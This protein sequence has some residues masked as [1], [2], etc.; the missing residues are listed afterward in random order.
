ML[1]SSDCFVGFF[2]C[3]LHVIYCTGDTFINSYNGVR[4][5]YKTLANR[6]TDRDQSLTN[7]TSSMH[8]DP[9]LRLA[10]LLSTITTECDQWT[11]LIQ[12]TQ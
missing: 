7:T 3:Y 11:H 9:R 6:L 5:G 2:G 1:M 12:G 10:Q 4:H 8:H